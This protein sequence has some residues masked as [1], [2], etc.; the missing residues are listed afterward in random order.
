MSDH[1]QLAILVLGDLHEEVVARRDVAEVRQ[2]L[3][4]G[5]RACACA[6]GYTR[7]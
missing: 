4:V 7:A 6:C 2:V 5:A 3:L 1:E